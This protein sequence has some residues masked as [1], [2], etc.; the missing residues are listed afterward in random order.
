MHPE[1]LVREVNVPEV[2]LTVGPGGEVTDLGLV[3][4]LPGGQPDIVDGVGG[5]GRGVG[6]EVGGEHPVPEEGEELVG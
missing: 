2:E 5:R 6:R 1:H 3:F 4:K